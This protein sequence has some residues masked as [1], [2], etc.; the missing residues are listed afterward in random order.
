[1]EIAIEYGHEE[2][3]KKN[4]YLHVLRCLWGSAGWWL[5][6]N[7]QG[8]SWFFVQEEGMANNAQHHGNRAKVGVFDI[9]KERDF[10]TVLLFF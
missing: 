8:E 7:P 1:M 2:E 5:V 9:A 4:Q 6:G 3:Q 10:L